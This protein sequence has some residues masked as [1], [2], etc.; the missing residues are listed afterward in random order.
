MTNVFKE[1]I[2]FSLKELL[3]FTLYSFTNSDTSI[4]EITRDEIAGKSM[5]EIT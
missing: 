4:S 5:L 1:K 2:Y 3:V